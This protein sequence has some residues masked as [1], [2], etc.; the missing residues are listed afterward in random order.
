MKFSLI[1]ALSAVLTALAACS[2]VEQ[3][4]SDGPPVAKFVPVYVGTAAADW[5]VSSVRIDVPAELT[6]SEADRYY[7]LSDI[8]WR[9]DPPGDRRQ[10]VA[11]LM[12]EAVIDGLVHLRGGQDVYMELAVTRFHSVT[13]RARAA[14]GGVHNIEFNLSVF[15]AETGLQIVGPLPMDASL[16]AFGGADAIKADQRGETQ[17]VRIRRHLTEFMR[18][19]L[20]G[21][22]I[23]D[24]PEEMDDAAAQTVETEES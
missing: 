11:T 12:Q 13:E 24:L 17:K 9:G 21:D 5:T 3:P 1:A 6:V 19:E 8:V 15:D 4:T 20:P 10:Q 22:G 14:I 16:N 18:I 2:F 23:F 7:P